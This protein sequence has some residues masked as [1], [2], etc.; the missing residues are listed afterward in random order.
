MKTINKIEE[1][2]CLEV[3]KK[4]RWNWQSLHEYGK[5]EY[6]SLRNHLISEQGGECAY[7]GLWIGEGTKQ[8]IHIDHFRK[9]SIYPQLEFEWLNLF[10]AVKNS[11][12]GADRKD[13][14]IGGSLRHAEK[15]YG[16]I[17]S[18][19][20]ANLADKFWYA[21]DGKVEPHPHLS[22]EEKAITNKTIE[23]FNLNSNELRERRK[24]IKKQIRDLSG[25]G[26]D[27]IK[28]C[29]CL[30]GFSFVVDFELKNRISDK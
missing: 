4:N 22:I 28:D 19:L 21:E 15:Q 24:S 1:P 23:V 6:E 18:P 25:M 27:I 5:S 29:F 8:T 9:R 16:E 11:E 20:Q 30:S 14:W 2:L 17:W 10:G 13:K 3:A 12:Y 26:D 7:T